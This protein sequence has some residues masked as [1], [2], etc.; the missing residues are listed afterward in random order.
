M[1]VKNSDESKESVC[2]RIFEK[3]IEATYHS[4][5]NE[6]PECSIKL[7]KFGELCPQNVRLRKM[8]QRAV[9]CC[10]IHVNVDYLRKAAI[11]YCQIIGQDSTTI[12]CNE[13]LCDNILCEE[14]NINSYHRKCTDC[15]AKSLTGLKSLICSSKCYV[16]N[17]DCHAQDHVINFKQFERIEYFHASKSKKK[18][19]LNDKCVTFKEF[20]QYFHEKIGT[21]AGH[22]FNLKHTDAMI[23]N[24]LESLRDHE[25][26]IV[27]DFSENCNCLLPDEPQSIHRTIQQATVYPVVTLR[28]HNK[29]IVED[30]FVFISDDR[31]HDFSFVEYCADHVKEFYSV[32]HPNIIS[33]IELNDGC[34]QQF[35]SIKAISK[36][37]GWPYYLSRLFFE[38][39]HGKS[40]SDGL[41]RVVKSFVSRSVNSEGT[42]LR[43][44]MEFYQF[45]TENLTFQNRD[46]V[47]NNRCFILVKLEDLENS[48]AEVA[49]CP[50]KTIPR[51]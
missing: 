33:L 32:N 21:F 50:C 13:K 31:T 47:F 48:L 42:V 6:N 49:K 39:S 40:K 43:N 28:Y 44:A 27:Q 41:G 20:V 4:F 45:C 37:I 1:L 16:E 18:L 46:G 35:E 17:V 23:D 26:V 5:C 25:L 3:T 34:A 12:S 8:A 14:P 2:L 24:L 10:T 7:R 36:L 9:C 19:S 51:T 22:R 11:R 29:N 38:T 30:H 15:K